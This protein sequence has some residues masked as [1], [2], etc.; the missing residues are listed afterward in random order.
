[1][2][3][4]LRNGKYPVTMY[5]VAKALNETDVPVT[6]EEIIESQSFANS[7]ANRRKVKELCEDLVQANLAG[8]T[9][10]SARLDK[11]K[12]YISTDEHRGV[13]IKAQDN[14]IGHR[15]Q[16]D[17]VL[18]EIAYMTEHNDTI[19]AYIKGTELLI[20]MGAPG[21][22]LLSKLKMVESLIDKEGYLAPGLSEYRGYLYTQ[23][24]SLA[25][26]VLNDN[27]Y[28]KFYGSF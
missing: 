12:A 5:G 25:V 21:D 9:H 22:H 15:V 17:K 10:Y 8:D 18:V 4:E 19:G 11:K 1:M 14:V 27:D 7:E 23:M 26:N 16:F 2:N 13:E 24:K 6:V 28:Q 3:D 20:V